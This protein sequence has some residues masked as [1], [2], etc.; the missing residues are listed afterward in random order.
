MN[1]SSFSESKQSQTKPLLSL[2]AFAV[3]DAG[4]INEANLDD[5][6][7]Y[8]SKRDDNESPNETFNV[9]TTTTKM[10]LLILKFPAQLIQVIMNFIQVIMK[11]KRYFQ[12]PYC[13][14]GAH[15]LKRAKDGQILGE[16]DFI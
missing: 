13:I 4:Q 1:K 16:L 3:A 10:E 9:T 5:F 2:D 12:N 8:D 14:I 15:C 7:K 11:K 6:N